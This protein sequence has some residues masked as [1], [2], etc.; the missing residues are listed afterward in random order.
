[1]TTGVT[2]GR[3]CQKPAIAKHTFHRRRNPYGGMKVKDAERLKELKQENARLKKRVA[4]QA[5]A[6]AIP[7]ETLEEKW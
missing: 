7:E 5:L 4:D 3:V 2:L 1:M 6:R